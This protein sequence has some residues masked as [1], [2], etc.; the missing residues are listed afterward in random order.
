ME[1]LPALMISLVS[2]K[3]HM[4]Q[5]KVTAVSANEAAFFYL[6]KSDPLFVVSVGQPRGLPA[7]RM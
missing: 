1:F 3:R 6:R 2:C 5:S 7:S 4:Q